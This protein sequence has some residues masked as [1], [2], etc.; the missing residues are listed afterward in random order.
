MLIKA[1]KFQ[2]TEQIYGSVYRIYMQ[3]ITNDYANNNMFVKRKRV[4]QAN[5]QNKVWI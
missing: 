2:I 3:I 1:V 5:E 4:L